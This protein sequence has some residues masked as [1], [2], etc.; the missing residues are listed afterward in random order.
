MTVTI[1]YK[2]LTI[3]YKLLLELCHELHNNLIL[4]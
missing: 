3:T 4:F 1:N 2:L